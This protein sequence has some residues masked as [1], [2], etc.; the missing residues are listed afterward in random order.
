M[1]LLTQSETTDPFFYNR[2]EMM[3]SLD[4]YISY[5]K[6]A[7]VS[8]DNIRAMLFEIIDTVSFRYLLDL[9]SKPANRIPSDILVISQTMKSDRLR[10]N[11]RIAACKLIESVLLHCRGLVDQVSPPRVKMGLVWFVESDYVACVYS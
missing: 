7:L 5:G 8:N 1:I 11:D 4:N 3:P 2:V 10:E 6:D 9:S